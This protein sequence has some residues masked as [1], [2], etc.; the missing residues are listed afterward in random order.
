MYQ[1]SEQL[2]DGRKYVHELHSLR[3][4]SGYY[5]HKLNRDDLYKELVA[6]KIPG[7]ENFMGHQQ[8]SVLF[9]RWVKDQEPKS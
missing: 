7:V 5:A 6:L 3:L 4:P 2:A 8:L 1:I 9:S